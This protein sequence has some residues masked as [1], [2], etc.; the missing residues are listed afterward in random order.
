MSKNTIRLIHEKDIKTGYL[1]SVGSATGPLLR[2]DGAEELHRDVFLLLK[3][4]IR[5]SKSFNSKIHH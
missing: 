5:P 3:M 2:N 1:I 4:M